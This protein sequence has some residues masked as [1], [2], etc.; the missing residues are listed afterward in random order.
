[1]E[2]SALPP[3]QFQHFNR[4]ASVVMIHAMKRLLGNMGPMA[5]VLA[6]FIFLTGCVT[7]P[8]R[9]ILTTKAKA[10]PE[11]SSSP[12]GITALLDAAATS[13][14]SEAGRAAGGRWLRWWAEHDRRPRAIHGNWTVEIVD[15]GWNSNY[16]DE[17]L[18]ATDYE[19]RG[20]SSRTIRPGRG[21]A[22]IGAREN[23]ASTPEERYF[24]AELITRPV[25]AVFVP[26]GSR[27]LVIELRDPLSD[28]SLAADFSAPFAHL[29]SR[30]GPVRPLGIGGF[31]RPVDPARRYGIFLLEPYDPNKTPVLFVH[32]LLATPLAW[33]RLTHDLW[34]DD[35][36]RH[37][38]QVWH[39]FYPTS[40]P[41]LYSSKHLRID[42]E[43]ARRTLDPSGKHRASQ[44]LDIVAHSMGGLLS[45]TL[46]TESGEKVWNT[47][48]TVPSRELEATDDDRNK[49]HDILHWHPR[50]D[51]RRV[52]FI[53]T[54]HRGSR[55]SLNPIGR[56]G[57]LLTSVPTPFVDLYRRLHAENPDALHPFFKSILPRGRLSS[58]DTLSPRHPTLPVLVDL[59]MAPRVTLHSIIGERDLI[60]PYPSSHLDNAASELH[61][62]AGHG[63]F[64]ASEAKEEVLRI[65]RLDRNSAD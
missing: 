24:P 41:F 11:H 52:I 7:P 27:R 60:V 47:V 23:R 43:E 10:A 65:L 28:A 37:H 14:G 22:L 61:V 63:A 17:L 29:L 33:A 25:T 18:P 34:A 53:A 30:A 5:A 62:P 13:P 59:P 44:R 9:L 50:Q 49:V 39:Y 6:G 45:R 3:A 54:P 1:M 57:D 26:H 20:F 35:E 48:F 55:F 19:V 40:A 31:F 21:I 4:T 56:L 51:V 42:V 36:F 32:G 46:F 12:E 2:T 8:A 15:R 64:K 38:H 16:F 58:I